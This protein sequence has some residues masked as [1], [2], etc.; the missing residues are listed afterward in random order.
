M[1][2]TDIS[3]KVC[4]NRFL[5]LFEGASQYEKFNNIVQEIVRSDEHSAKFISLGLNPEH[6]GT[7]S[8]R[9]GA[10]THASMDITS[11]PLTSYCFYLHS[12]KLEDAG[13]YELLHHCKQIVSKTFIYVR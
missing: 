13:S 7:H 6:F 4:T 12:C 1:N 9:K 2:F 8:I 10:I 11:S 5:K 3:L